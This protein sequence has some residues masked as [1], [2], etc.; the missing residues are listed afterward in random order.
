MKAQGRA[1]QRGFDA[2]GVRRVAHDA[3]GDAK[4]VVVHRARRRHADVPIAG[5][6]RIV[7]HAGV[8]AGFQHL[9][10]GG[11]V[12]EAVQ[13]TRGKLAG[14][15]ALVG[16]DLAQVVQVG[17]DA[18]QPRAVQGV[19]QLVQRGLTRIRVHDQLGQHRVIER[20]H[21]RARRHPAVHPHAIRKRHLGQHAR[22]G[23][24]L[25]QRVLGIQPH[26]DRRALR[27]ARHGRIVQRFARGH[28]Q[29]AFH[30][31]QAGHGFGHGMLDLQARVDLQ[32]VEAVARR[33]VDE[34]HRASRP[35][36][37]GLA[38]L[39]GGVEQ[40]GARGGRQQGRRG[41]FDD[42]L[43]APLHRAI[44]FAQRQHA[45]RAIAEDLHLDVPRV[46]HIAF[47]ECAAIA[48]EVFAHAL[49][50]VERHRQLGLAVA[51]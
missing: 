22:R 16:D 7:L 36:V 44:A 14:A 46:I 9:D 37:H 2:G 28:A 38:Q 11:A 40:R 51:A 33:V 17:G 47:D 10:R 48:E 31:V 27:G 19:G 45:S 26:L 12:L 39:D 15:K 32:E 23:L 1:D 21:V 43:V 35:V 29:H 50:A 3:V 42:L 18:V 6:A 25:A 4:G 5:A 13:E 34:F 24:E 30:Q 41:F 49:H 8:G 20:G